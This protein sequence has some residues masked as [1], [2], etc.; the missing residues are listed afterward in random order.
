MKLN[1][2]TDSQLSRDISH[3]IAREREIL[4]EILHHLIEIERRKLF[5]ESQCGSLYEYCIKI[6][7][8]SEGEASRRISAC[9]LLKDIP[10]ISSDI[11]SGELNLT[12]LNL[13]KKYFD[14]NKISNNETKC[15]ILSR[16]KGKT[17]RQS[18]Q[19][20]WQLQHGNVQRKVQ[21]TLL[22]ETVEKLQEVKNLKAHSFKNFDSLL[23]A[24]SI[25]VLKIWNPLKKNENKIQ[26]SSKNRYIPRSLKSE[27]WKRDQGKC[28]ICSSKY[29]LQIDHITPYAIGGPTSV[30]NLRLLCRN[31]NQ[32]QSFKFFQK[33][34]FSS[35]FATD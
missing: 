30:D 34:S 28:S 23:Q 8:Y 16:L 3:L 33:S 18:E 1:H 2:L 24:M 11:I 22:E 25:E 17:T 9:R 14:E 31:C 7:N 27:L 6:L 19:I 35:S 4:H 29:A 20:L 21:L 26:T 15:E 12:K 10:I 13:A 32:R 5:S